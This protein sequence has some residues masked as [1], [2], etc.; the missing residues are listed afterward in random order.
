MR[1]RSTRALPP[2]RSMQPTL[3]PAP[4]AMRFTP[5]RR[6]ARVLARLRAMRLRYKIAWLVA[7]PAI[8]VLGWM[9]LRD[10][11][12]FSVEEVTIAGIAPD[13][14]P[15]VQEDLFAAARS[16][17]TTDFSV[18]ALRSAVAPYT[19]IAGVRAQT[20]FPHSVRIEVVERHPLAH[21]Q[22]GHRWFL[23]AADGTIVTGARARDPAVLR[24]TSLPAGGRTRDGFVLMALRILAAA[25]A[26]LRERVV[27]ITAPHGL[28]TIYL[29]RGPRLI[30][31][32]PVLPHAKWDAVAA[33]LSVPSSRG[34]SY[35]DVQVPSR[36]AAQVADPATMNLQPGGSLGNAP[37]GAATVSTVLD[38]RLVEPS[39]YTSGR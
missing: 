3:A 33:V 18:G 29:H 4:W 2:L 31:G 10:S 23:V 32:N 22:V 15:G 13:V 25:P 7:V 26:P 35:V 6:A 37:S 9:V 5:A 11:R 27:A 14:Q 19:V 17:T 12:L 24:S 1:P 8:G 16:Q 30:F 36:P 38:P 39:T 20:S 34:A 28:L 21:L